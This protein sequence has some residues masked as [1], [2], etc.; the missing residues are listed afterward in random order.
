MTKAGPEQIIGVTINLKRLLMLIPLVLF[1]GCDSQTEKPERPQGAGVV[2]LPA[3][4][5]D[6]EA[7]GII[8]QALVN[9][10]PQVRTIAIEI[11]ASIPKAK[12]RR[13][14]PDVQRLLADE[15]VPVR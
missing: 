4:S 13:F 7:G 8:Q 14:M 2:K 10:N 6:A 15:Y 1:C 9:S 11:V 5:I 12:G 3:G